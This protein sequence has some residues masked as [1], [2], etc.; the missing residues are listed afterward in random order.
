MTHPTPQGSTPNSSKQTLQ[1]QIK[2]IADKAFMEDRRVHVED[3]MPF[4]ESYVT[5]LAEER[6]DRVDANVWHYINQWVNNCACAACIEI[7]RQ[8]K[9]VQLAPQK[10]SE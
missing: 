6:S 10:E 5:T 3:L 4:I 7:R 9:R 8:K 2:E 1:K